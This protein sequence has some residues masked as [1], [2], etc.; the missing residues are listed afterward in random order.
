MI[1]QTRNN[2]I[3]SLK[4]LCALLVI[5]LHVPSSLQEYYMPLTRCAVPVFFIISGYFLYGNN[6]VLKIKRQLKRISYILLWGSILYAFELLVLN[7]GSISS[8]IPTTQDLFN[9]ACFNE[10]PYCPHLWYLSA[11]IYVLVIILAIEKLN[12]WKIFFISIPF[13]LAVDLCF[14]KYSI[15]LWNREFDW[16]YVRNFLFVGLP[17]VLIGAYIRKFENKV[18]RI[19]TMFTI[20]G[21]ILFSTTSFVERELLIYLGA[22]AIREH[23]ISTTF[24]AVTLFLT[25]LNNKSYNNYKL[26]QFGRNDS[27][28]IY[29]FHIMVSTF[30]N[31]GIKHSHL[32]WLIE[33]YSI[34]APIFVL[35]VTLLFVM[36]LR[37]FTIIK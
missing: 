9:F 21:V 22:N 3:D 4:G 32:P 23:Y 26:S 37:K 27:L 6:I 2:G 15:V 30:L 34:F 24:M 11:Y 7:H 5:F 19:S 31:I 20:G 25:F 1:I 12:L 18:K 28:Y 36:A 10:N 8:I 17:Y 16:L 29:V 33:L 14:G 35:I 13:L